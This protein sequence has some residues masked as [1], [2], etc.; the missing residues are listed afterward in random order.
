MK[1][2]TIKTADFK[3][4]NT[5]KEKRNMTKELHDLLVEIGYYDEDKEESRRKESRRKREKAIEEA[6]K[7]A[8]I[9]FEETGNLDGEDPRWLAY[10]K[11][12]EESGLFEVSRLPEE[13]EADG[14]YE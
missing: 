12:I 2:Y 5:L 14:V 13:P 8:G 1:T 4:T 11:K 7:Y 9:K 6:C 10:S 3:P